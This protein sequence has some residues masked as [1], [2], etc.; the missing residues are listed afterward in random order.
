MGLKIITPYKWWKVITHNHKA[1]D[2]KCKINFMSNTLIQDLE[3]WI[4]TQNWKHNKTTPWSFSLVFNY[5]NYT[6]KFLFWMYLQNSQEY[7]F[8]S[9][10][11]K[12]RHQHLLSHL[13][14]WT[15]GIMKW[16][17]NTSIYRIDKEWTIPY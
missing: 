17:T 16:T 12:T 11:P 8:V 10:F 13:I 1:L 7:F 5:L 2:A 3:S 9:L 4:S 15:L 6:F 14:S